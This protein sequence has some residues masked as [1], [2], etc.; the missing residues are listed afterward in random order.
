MKRVVV[1]FAVLLSVVTIA[2]PRPLAQP[3]LPSA[4]EFRLVEA[5]VAD[6]QRALQTG[7]ITSEQLVQMYLARLAVYEDVGPAVNAFIYVNPAALNEA[8]QL[9]AARHPG[10]AAQPPVRHSRGAERHHRHP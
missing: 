1:T 5:T 10:I 2:A 3:Q 8:R 7:L 9:D 4:A 6:M